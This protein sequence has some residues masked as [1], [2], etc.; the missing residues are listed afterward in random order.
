MPAR[1]VV[2][3]A[4]PSA[5]V[6]LC[7]AVLCLAVVLLLAAALLPAAARAAGAGF[8]PLWSQPVT[9]AERLVAGDGATVLWA[10]Q[11]SSSAQA[12]VARHYDGAGHT[13]A[14]GPVVLV[15]GLDGLGDWLAAPGR[16]G[17]VLLAWKTGGSVFVAARTAAGDAVFAAVAVCTDAAVAQARGAGATATPVAL[18]PDGRGG[19]Y[20]VLA[21]TPSASTGD[22][23]LTHVSATGAPARP[24]PGLF[25]SDGTIVRAGT[26]GEGHLLALLGGPGRSGVALQRYSPELAADWASPA[27]P[28]NPLVGPP[29]AA[30][31]PVTVGRGSG[32]GSWMAWREGTEVRLQRFS[33]AGDRIWFRPVA[34]AAAAGAAV[35]A[36]GGGGLYVTSAS[37]DLLIVSHVPADGTAA[38]KPIESRLQTGRQGVGIDAVTSDAA[39]DLDVAF[40]GATSGGVAEMTCVGAWTSPALAPPAARLAALAA[41]GSGGAFTLERGES[42]RLWRLGEAGTALTLRPRATALTYGDL[43]EVAG[44]LTVDGEPLAGVTVHLAPSAG[45]APPAATTFADG[46]YQTSFKPQASATWT[47]TAQ[48]PAGA[49]ISSGPSVRIEV[50]PTI[51]LS[52][53]TRR[54]GSGYVTAFSGEVAPDHRGSTVLVQR[55]RKGGWSLLTSAKVD[56]SSAYRAT[57]KIPLKTATYLI[58]TVLPA[59]GDH[60]EGVSRTARLRVVVRPG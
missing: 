40:S 28:Y 37:S 18:Q 38:G 41:D 26:D 12:L 19:A 24:D 32:S 23:L 34:V 58:R 59:H 30:Q 36:D 11:E 13:S 57:W 5:I 1:R 44:Y 15:D 2:T 31:T 56:A 42:G 27:S 14:G 21:V 4:S 33:S 46:L 52:I 29:S 53:D 25:V 8:A 60:A 47:A 55:Q 22:T 35:A 3:A 54:A 49:T 16:D 7:A 6:V 9:G 10:A 17:D 51:S 39:G 48:G 45:A 43:L 50:A 20:L